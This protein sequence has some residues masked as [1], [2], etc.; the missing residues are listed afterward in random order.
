MDKILNAP[1]DVRGELP[2]IANQMEKNGKKIIYCNIG[3]PLALE[4]EPIYKY[5]EFLSNQL[6]EDSK[7]NICKVDIGAYSPS[8]GFPAVIKSVQTFINKRDNCNTQDN[9][10]NYLTNGATEAIQT[11]LKVYLWNENDVILLPRPAYPIYHAYADVFGASVEYYDLDENWKINLSSIV[12]KINHN[13]KSNKKIVLMVIIN[14]NN[15]TGSILSYN[16][17]NNVAKIAEKEQIPLISDE[18]YMENDL[19]N[20]FISMRKVVIEN[21]INIKLFSLHSCSKGFIGECGFRGGYLN[22]LNLTQ[23]E[24]DVIEKYLSMRL[25]PNSMGQLVM[26]AMTS[27]YDTEEV[28]NQINQKKEKYKQKLNFLYKELNNIGYK[29]IRPEGAMYIFPKIPLN[30]RIN[31]IALEENREYDFIWCREFLKEHNICV[32]PGSGFRKPGYFRMTILPKLEDL[33]YF[34]DCLKKFTPM[35]HVG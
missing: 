1:Y 22:N 9:E 3:N 26:Y 11:I 33:H 4:P 16:Q 6:I 10:I 2:K 15:P 14:P 24:K 29:C 5:R 35:K 31:K 12:E 21:K 18:V 32:I 30:D 25:S 23:K 8:A 19:E 7:K 28:I 34:I 17:L 27:L 13:K 20:R